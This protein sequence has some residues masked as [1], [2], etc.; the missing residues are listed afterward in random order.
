MSCSSR[1]SG[2]SSLNFAY[3]CLDNKRVSKVVCA[4]VPC[5]FG[6]ILGLL[7]FFFPSGAIMFWCL[8]QL[9]LFFGVS[10]REGW[11]DNRI[12]KTKSMIIEE[13]IENGILFGVV[14]TIAEILQRS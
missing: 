11:S 3:K 4:R 7:L 10:F 6:S 13:G 12:E 2:Y 14:A 5:L 9:C 1:V 8:A